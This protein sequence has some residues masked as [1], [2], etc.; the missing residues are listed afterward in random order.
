MQPFLPGLEPVG[1]SADDILAAVYQGSAEVKVRK[2]NRIYKGTRAPD[3][4]DPNQSFWVFISDIVPEGTNLSRIQSR[5]Q[6]T[7]RK[8]HRRRYQEQL[9]WLVYQRRLEVRGRRPWLQFRVPIR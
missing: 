6:I 4:S 2:H 9:L 8:L 1:F 3:L 7:E 5:S